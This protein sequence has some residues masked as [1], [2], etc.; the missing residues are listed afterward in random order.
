MT[1][2]IKSLY[3]FLAPRTLA[4]SKLTQS[5]VRIAYIVMQKVTNP[6]RGH[7]LLQM[8]FPRKKTGERL[9]TVW[10][11]PDP[12]RDLTFIPLI[13]QIPTGP[14]QKIRE[15]NHTCWISVRLC[16]TA[17]NIVSHMHPRWRAMIR[18]KINNLTKV[19]QLYS[20]PPRLHPL[21]N[22]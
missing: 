2:H 15:I 10:I 8:N 19:F 6:A 14:K 3:H 22:I 4:W 12:W 9:F 21:R 20:H 7:H 16:S 18:S 11:I 1:S 17:K 13:L 5:T